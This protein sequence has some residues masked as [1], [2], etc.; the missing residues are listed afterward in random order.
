[1]L[2]DPSACFL[3]LGLGLL[4]LWALLIIRPSDL[5]WELKHLVLSFMGLQTTL[6]VPWV[7]TMQ[8]AGGVSTIICAGISECISLYVHV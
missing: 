6:L 1:M 5:A 8:T 7:C 3:E 2:K 4:L